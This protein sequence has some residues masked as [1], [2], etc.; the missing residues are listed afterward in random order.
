MSACLYIVSRVSNRALILA[1][2]ESIVG[3]SSPLVSP[4]SKGRFSTPS[5]RTRRAKSSESPCRRTVT[6]LCRCIQFVFSH[7]IPPPVDMTHRLY[8]ATSARIM[9]SMARNS[10]SPASAK[11]SLGVFFVTLLMSSS[12]SK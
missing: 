7:T 8:A 4:E 10:L 5:A 6:P 11:S 9:L 3:C 12:V 1:T 2:M